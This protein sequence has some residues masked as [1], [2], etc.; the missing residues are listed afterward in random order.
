MQITTLRHIAF[1]KFQD[2]NT[3]LNLSARN[4]HF[5]CMEL[6]IKVGADINHQDD[7]NH[8]SKFQDGNTALTLT[9]C[10]DNFECAKFL[11]ENEADVNCFDEVIT[12]F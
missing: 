5:E 12:S 4:G 3:A 10:I 11:I 6:L 1:S 2:G 8:D 7:V 9:T